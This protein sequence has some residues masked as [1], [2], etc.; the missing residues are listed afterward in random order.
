MNASERPTL[1]Y[2]L[3]EA[4][5]VAVWVLPVPTRVR[6][7]LS[8]LVY[9]NPPMPAQQ[10]LTAL[11][12]LSAA[13]VRAYCSGGWGVDALIGH[14]TRK[15]R[16]LDL[17]IDSADLDKAKDALAPL[18][19]AD[20]FQIES[21][22][23]LHSRIVVRD[24]A[25]R[26]I[27]LHPAELDAIDLQLA[28]GTIEGQ[29]APCLS[30]NVQARAHAGYRKRRRD[31]RDMR[32]L[33]RILVGPVTA[34]VIPVGAAEHLVEPTA[35]D[36]GMPPHV[37]VLYPFVAGRGLD[38][39]AERMLARVIENTPAFSFR[40]CKVAQFPGVVY[41]AP[42]PAEPFADLTRAV[43]EQWPD[44]PPY[45]GAFDEIVP[46]L[47]IARAD[48]PPAGI[49]QRLPITAHAD[50]VWLMAHSRRGWACRTRFALG[51]PPTG[52]RQS[53]QS[54]PEPEPE[55]EPDAAA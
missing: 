32:L 10:V 6:A 54:Q 29:P 3:T 20:W 26:T 42:E 12:V 15:H 46:H 51:P 13:G 37:T 5:N 39:I 36:R 9:R 50:E 27:D 31:R 28:E 40:L 35:R 41:V 17:V 7:L 14:Q 21:D 43:V 16:D 25:A 11:G 23:P 47:T 4:L 44:H 30:A 2:R 22:V 38:L 19:Y 1:W 34:L 33:E 45:R 8:R 24:G 49:A 55:P 53:A 18:G 48:A 52:A